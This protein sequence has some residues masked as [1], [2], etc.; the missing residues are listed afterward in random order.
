MMPLEKIV[1]ECDATTASLFIESQANKKSKLM[2]T[3]ITGASSGIGKALSLECASRG[4][5]LLLVALPGEELCELEKKILSQY[6]V[7]C[8]SFG[9][10][11][12]KHCSYVDVYNWVKE[13]KYAV[14]I[15]INNVGLG[16]KGAFE[17]ISTDFYHMQLSLNIITTCMLTRLFVNDLKA[18]APAHIL[19]VGSLGGFFSLPH[20]SVYAASKAFIYSF[21]K[22]IR[23]EFEPLG[24]KV[25]VLCPG[26]TNS[27]ERTIAIN[28]DLKGIAKTSILQPQ[29]V[30][31][32]AVDQM[33]KG[34]RRIIPG[35][36]NKFI[37]HLS[38]LTPEFLQDFFVRRAFSHVKR[39]EY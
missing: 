39:H 16:S 19:N 35:L 17:Q 1:Q 5:N 34:R 20:K 38:R 2:Y 29:Q 18:N 23:I 4:M 24:I 15:L 8:F 28:K 36:C 3:L 13:N 33:L 10:D 31:K 22:A 6:R 21:S 7:A 11:L 30:A 27:N 25:S 26:G 14:N 37:Y 12:S 32:E 9:T